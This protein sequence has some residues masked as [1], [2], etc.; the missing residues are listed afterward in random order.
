MAFVSNINDKKFE[1][2]FFFREEM[3]FDAKKSFFL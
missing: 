1:Y 2:F 3:I